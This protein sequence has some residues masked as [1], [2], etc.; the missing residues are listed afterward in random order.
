MTTEQQ[1]KQIAD[2][3]RHLVNHDNDARRYFCE[4]TCDFLGT[5]DLEQE[6]EELNDKIEELEE[7]IKSA[8]N[9]LD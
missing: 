3:L 4:Q 8:Q 9:A 1:I 5:P 7:K 6:I 2:Q